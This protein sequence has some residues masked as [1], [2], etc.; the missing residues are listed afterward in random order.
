MPLPLI[1]ERWMYSELLHYKR[2]L[3]SFPSFVQR[4]IILTE[5][6]CYK[7]TY[8]GHHPTSNVLLLNRTNIKVSPSLNKLGKFSLAGMCFSFFSEK[9]ENRA[10]RAKLHSKVRRDPGVT[11]KMSNDA[12]GNASN[13]AKIE[14]K[15]SSFGSVQEQEWTWGIS[16]SG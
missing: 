7:L 3:D 13:R 14:S 6:L 9:H 2:E 4:A 11:I 8:F 10:A 12:P 16:H 5:Y 1:A 15:T